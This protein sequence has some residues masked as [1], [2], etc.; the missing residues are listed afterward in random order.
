MSGGSPLAAREIDGSKR[1]RG[2][3]RALS[4]VLI[5]VAFVVH[6]VHWK[7]A[8]KTLAPLELNEV[9]YTLEL[10]IVTAGFLLMCLLMV[11]T[12]VFGRFFC[13]WACHIL[14]LQDLCA[15][16]LRKLGIRARPVRSRLLLWAPPLIAAYMFAWPQVLRV[17]RGEE[18]PTL[19]LATDEA[20]WASFLTESFWR[21]LPS[22]AVTL[23]TFLV[24]GFLIVYLLGSRSFCS[25]V[26]PYGAIFGLADR[27]APG[28]IREVGSCVQCG[29]CTRVCT[30]G[31]RV[32]EEIGR[33]AMVVNTA[34]LKDLDCV[35]ACPEGA[36]SFAFGRPR[37]F[38]LAGGSSRFGNRFDFTLPEELVMLLVFLP[39]V[40][41][42]RGLYGRVPFLLSLAAGVIAGFAV[43]TGGRMLSRRDVTV[44]GLVAKRCGRFTVAGSAFLILLGTGIYFLGHSAMVRYHGMRGMGLMR[45]TV[46]GSG[47]HR[48][49]VLEA[50]EH[51]LRAEALGILSDP[52][53]E[54]NLFSLA[55]DLGR[56][57]E[58]EQRGRCLIRKELVAGTEGARIHQALG[59]ILVRRGDHVGAERE[60]ATAVEL[61]PH[62]AT[63]LAALGSIVAERGDFETALARLREAVGIDPALHPAHYNIGAI[64]AS[65]GRWE[66][67]VAAYE[68][69]AAGSPPDPDLENNL[70]QTLLQLGRPD[71]ASLHLRRALVLDPHHAHAHFN[72][73][74]ALI[75]KGEI[76]R[77]RGHI[78]EAARWDARYRQLVPD[79]DPR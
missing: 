76:E 9:M 7:L 70:G 56:D 63:A 26:C 79:P 40:L 32:H 78:R 72:L 20:G 57:E 47:D 49:S 12:A 64:Q 36:I 17:I 31:I 60:L 28:K 34:C 30:S 29:T 24:C 13:S 46:Q 48:R 1:T 66:E 2:R 25:Y 27:L 14:A 38:T 39:S 42:L 16:M 51:L 11:G 37:I 41:V 4:L 15:W 23:V 54:R 10:G 67:A 21:N 43:V 18:L 65:R 50:R 68:A 53:V 75:V 6:I 3:W 22:P 62:C 61:D 19:H 59:E 45:G 52:E 44:A 69:A 35:D 77:G 58:A 8:G 33:H 55:L 5:H 73:G 71:E 74:R